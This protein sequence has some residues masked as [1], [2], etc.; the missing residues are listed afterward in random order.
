MNNVRKLWQ[1]CDTVIALNM[2]SDYINEVSPTH[3]EYEKEYGGLPLFHKKTGKKIPII[4]AH[5]VKGRDT[6]TEILS[7]VNALKYNELIEQ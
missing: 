3:K 5:I 2:P 4:Y 7:F 6:G 1:V